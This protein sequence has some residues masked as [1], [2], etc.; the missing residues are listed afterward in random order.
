MTNRSQI[1][2]VANRTATTADLLS[3]VE[4]RAR[5]SPASFHLLIPAEPSGLHRVVDPEVAGRDQARARLDA[6]LPLLRDAAG[7]DVTGHVGDADALAA[8]Q[9][10]LHQRRFDEIVI[11]TLPR[12]VSRWLKLDLPSKARA[13]GLPVVHVETAEPVPAG[14]R[15]AEPERAVA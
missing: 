3:A 13:L 8:I 10:A 7:S 4:R 9:D 12:R 6:A 11:S 15:A 5:L 2:I 14:G 1:L